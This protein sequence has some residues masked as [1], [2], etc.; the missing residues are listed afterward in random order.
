M[1]GCRRA[2]SRRIGIGALQE[3]GL[4]EEVKVAKSGRLCYTVFLEAH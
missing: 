2:G 4:Q 1:A 3:E